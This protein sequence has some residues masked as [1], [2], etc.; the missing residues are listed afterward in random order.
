MKYSLICIIVILCACQHKMTEAEAWNQRVDSII[1]YWQGRK[2]ILPADLPV[3]T[4]D[5]SNFVNGATTAHQKMVTYVD[6]TC[7]VCITNLHHWKAF[8]NDIRAS[9]G[10]VDFIF[11]IQS[12]NKDDFKKDIMDTL[13]LGVTWMH[14]SRNK[15]LHD[16]NLYD[17]RFQTALLDDSDRV[18]LL[19]TM[20][21][22]QE[23]KELFKKTILEHSR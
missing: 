17:Q 19:G 5:T 2:M 11:Y 1:T 14:D 9:H 23:L 7:G 22:R 13:H 3:M 4:R 20:E 16:N 15:F 18:V 21:D 8:I 6:G 12:E 10:K